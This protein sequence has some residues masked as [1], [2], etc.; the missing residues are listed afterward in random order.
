[1]QKWGK[2]KHE[3]CGKEGNLHHK[4]QLIIHQNEVA[5]GTGKGHHIVM[6][7]IYIKIDDCRIRTV[8][9]LTWHSLLQCDYCLPGKCEHI[10]KTENC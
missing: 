2:E 8:R 6:S 4:S 1:M 5:N 3:R 10:C 9:V 7:K